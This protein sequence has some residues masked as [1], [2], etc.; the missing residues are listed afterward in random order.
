LRGISYD[1][2]ESDV[3]YLNHDICITHTTINNKESSNFISNHIEIATTMESALIRDTLSTES[4]IDEY[5]TY[6]HYGASPLLK[7]NH[8]YTTISG[9]S[10]IGADFKIIGLSTSGGDDISKIAIVSGGN[11]NSRIVDC[12]EYTYNILN[13]AGIDFYIPLFVYKTRAETVISCSVPCSGTHKTYNTFY[14]VTKGIGF[15]QD[16]LFLVSNLSQ[17]NKEKLMQDT[18]LDDNNIPKGYIKENGI[19]IKFS[20]YVIKEGSGSVALY[21]LTRK[22]KANFNTYMTQ[23]SSTTM[24]PLGRNSSMR[25][26]HS[27]R[28]SPLNTDQDSQSFQGGG[29]P[30]QTYI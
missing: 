25:H 30:P 18:I 6:I 21:D 15:W 8:R 23:Q 9:K 27:M 4:V 14:P 5:N 29:L 17:L 26:V 20:D 28:V 19:L 11:G 1:S 22:F 12:T 16:L 13:V 3:D 2:N 24:V 7:S 10:L